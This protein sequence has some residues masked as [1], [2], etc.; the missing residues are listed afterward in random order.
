MFSFHTAPSG[1]PKKSV[2]FIAL[3]DL[4]H[5]ELEAADEY[6]YDADFDTINFILD[7]TKAMQSML[8]LCGRLRLY[9]SYAIEGLPSHPAPK[10]IGHAGVS[11]P[12]E[13][14]LQELLPA[15]YEDAL[16][17]ALSNVCRDVQMSMPACVFMSVGVAIDAGCCAAGI[18]R[19]TVKGV[20]ATLKADKGHSLTS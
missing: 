8:L 9:M 2:K 14:R 12:A 13:F 4:G 19:Q 11:G 10:Q 7:D 16:L 3:A 1:G 5:A 6:D 15:G 17:S 20:L 18:S